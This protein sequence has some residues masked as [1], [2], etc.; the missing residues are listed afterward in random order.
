MAN[1]K[2]SNEIFRNLSTFYLLPD[3][4]VSLLASAIHRMPLGRKQGVDSA[5]R[6]LLLSPLEVRRRLL[7]GLTKVNKYII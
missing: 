7:R 1:T 5:H 3:L 2:V 6:Y 4:F